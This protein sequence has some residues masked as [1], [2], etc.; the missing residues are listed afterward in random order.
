MPLK[1]QSIARPVFMYTHVY[2]SE[3]VVFDNTSM[4]VYVCV[5]VCVCVCVW[6][7]VCVCVRVC[8]CVCVYMS[9]VCI[10][11]NFD[12]G[13]FSTYMYNISSH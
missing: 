12:A 10:E 2:R 5:C 1:E 11:R 8:V 4:C 3:R 13:F 7:G 6:M 9:H